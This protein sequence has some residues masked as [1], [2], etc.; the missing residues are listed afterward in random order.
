MYFLKNPSIITGYQE[1]KGLALLCPHRKRR[2]L[3]PVKSNEEILEEIMDLYLDYD[4]RSRR[5]RQRRRRRNRKS[6]KP[7][8]IGIFLLLIA[9]IGGGIYFGRKYAAYRQEQ[10]EKARK[11]AEAKKTVTV[12]FPE[13]YSIN[14]MAKRL[15]DQKIFQAEEFLAAVKKTDQYHNDW[16]KKLPMKKGM[17]YQ[18]EGY[19]YPD[20]YNIYKN[21]KP[22]ELIQKMLDNFEKKYTE[23]KKNN[24]SRRSMQELIT[25]ASMIERE[26]KVEKERPVIAGVIENRLAKKMKLQIDPTVLYTTTDGL[27]N[28]KKVYYK[29]LKVQSAYNTYVNQGLPI[30]PICSPSVTAIKAAMNPSKHEYFYYRTDNTKKGTHV[31][32]KTFKE[33]QS[34]AE[35]K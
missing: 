13:G 17:K 25:M 26:A 3:K 28:A 32:T 21:A 19:L 12:M 4:N 30:G 15:E 9:V 10:A 2:I 8:I 22:E 7:V 5:R 33:H 20:T 24:K 16:V 29:D 11:L 18:L 34:A 23:A 35:K 1:A 6:R 14:M 31:F 27:Y